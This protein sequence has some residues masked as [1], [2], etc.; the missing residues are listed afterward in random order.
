MRA[1][2]LFLRSSSDA[3]NTRSTASQTRRKSLTGTN[4]YSVGAM[5]AMMERPPPTT[6]LKP[7][8]SCPS[9]SRTRGMKPMSWMLVMA[10]SLSQPENAVLILRGMDCVTGWRRK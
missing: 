10:Q 5:R 7:R 8:S 3:S 1:F 9:T 2:I 4:S 6:I